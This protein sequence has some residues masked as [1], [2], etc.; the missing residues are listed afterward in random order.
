MLSAETT[1]PSRHVHIQ[2]ASALGVLLGDV[3]STFGRA[4]DHRSRLGLAEEAGDG[5]IV[6]QVEAADVGRRAREAQADKRDTALLALGDHSASE[7]ARRSGHSDG[8]RHGARKT[9]AK[10]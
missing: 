4:V 9:S 2:R 3:R 5:R 10:V 1:Q 7:Q 8:L 6:R